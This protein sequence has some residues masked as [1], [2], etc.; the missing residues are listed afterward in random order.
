MV[1]QAASKGKNKPGRPARGTNRCR[2]RRSGQRRSGGARSWDNPRR[3]DSVGGRCWRGGGRSSSPSRPL[4]EDGPCRRPTPAG[5][6]GVQE[7]LGEDAGPVPPLLHPPPY[8]G[9]CRQDDVGQ[10]GAGGAVA[11]EDGPPAL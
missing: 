9:P 11:A 10:V 8:P 4:V 3:R 2:R 7:A 6:P 5:L 1:G